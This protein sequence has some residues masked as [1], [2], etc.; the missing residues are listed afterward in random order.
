MRECIMCGEWER[1]SHWF[2]SASELHLRVPAFFYTAVYLN[3]LYNTAKNASHFPL[4]NKQC[5]GL[6]SAV[7]KMWHTIWGGKINY[8][9]NKNFKN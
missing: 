9:T 4:N 1:N 6:H 2:T 8:A 7:N 3:R 5:T